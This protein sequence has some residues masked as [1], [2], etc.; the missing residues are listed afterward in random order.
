MAA[1]SLKGS[2]GVVSIVIPPR[3]RDSPPCRATPFAYGDNPTVNGLE[4]LFDVF[5]I[6]Q[7]STPTSPSPLIGVVPNATVKKA[8]PFAAST[9]LYK[10]QYAGSG[11]LRRVPTR[12]A[13]HKYRIHPIDSKFEAPH[14][15]I[16]DLSKTPD[17]L[18]SE[19]NHCK[20]SPTYSV[21][22]LPETTR[23]ASSAPGLQLPVLFAASQRSNFGAL[24][25]Y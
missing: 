9:A 10:D 1:Y 14:Y 21:F 8:E 12:P 5:S 6:R 3:E 13:H 17:D 2:I 4:H 24:L 19:R 18:S 11:G 22:L 15:R 16:T 20:G 23:F 7:R 25:L